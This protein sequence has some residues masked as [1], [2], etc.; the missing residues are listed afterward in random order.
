MFP[1][2]YILNNLISKITKLIFPLL[3]MNQKLNLRMRLRKRH[4]HI[5]HLLIE[6]NNFRG[7]GVV[8]KHS[9]PSHH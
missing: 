5:L 6:A 8:E 7:Q 3:N 9:T 4:L 1:K 2:E